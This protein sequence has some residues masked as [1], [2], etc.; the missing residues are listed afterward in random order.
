MNKPDPSELETQY[1]IEATDSEKSTQNRDEATERSFLKIRCPQC[2]NSLNV[3]TEKMDAIQCTTCGCNFNLLDE[4]DQ[5]YKS[6]AIRTI[7]H[8]ELLEQLGAGGFGTVWKA[9]DTALDRVVAVKIPRKDKLSREETEQFLREARAAAQL[10]HPNI[11]GVHEVGKD[12]DRVY[13]VSDLIRG[14]TLEDWL[15]AHVFTAQSAAKLCVKVADALAHA[16]A[17]RVVHRDIKPS[18]ILM[19]SDGEPFVTDF[20]LARRDVGELTV[21]V[22]GQMMGT[23]AYMSPEQAAGEGHH[24]DGRSDIYSLGVVLFRLITGELPFRGNPAMM[25]MQILNDEP[26]SPRKLNQAI[27]RDLETIV[28]KCLEKKREKRY[29]TATDLRSDLQSFIAGEPV[30]ARSIG[31]V[32][33]SLRWIARNP[34]IAALSFSIMGLLAT[35][36]LV[37]TTAAFKIES[38]RKRAVTNETRALIAEAASKQEKEKAEEALSREQRAM[39]QTQ[40]VNTDFKTTMGLQASEKNQ[41]A[42]SVLWFANAAKASADKSWR[43]QENIFRA[44]TWSDN[45]AKPIWAEKFDGSYPWKMEFD[46]DGRYLALINPDLALEVFDIQI[47][48][49]VELPTQVNDGVSGFAWHP[50]KSLMAISTMNA[51]LLFWDLE[52]NAIRHEMQ[53]EQQSRVLT[54]SNDGQMLCLAGNTPSLMSAEDYSM[55]NIAIDCTPQAVSAYFNEANDRV[56]L[57]CADSRV[58][59]FDAT[60]NGNGKTLFESALIANNNFLYRGSPFVSGNRLAIQK[61]SGIVVSVDCENGEVLQELDVGQNGKRLRPDFDAKHL[62]LVGAFSMYFLDLD[63]NKIHYQPNVKTDASN[64][65][66]SIDHSNM[67][68]DCVRSADG[69]WMATAAIDSE[70][71]IWD[72]GTETRLALSIPHQNEVLRCFFSPSSRHL[73]SVEVV[74]FKPLDFPWIL[75]GSGS[76]DAAS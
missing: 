68:Q 56:A 44:I 28:L 1:P 23:P 67:I 9:R 59:L 62:P 12:G 65:G 36:A 37:S 75:G 50:A 71:R 38:S 21:T 7:A 17:Q 76:G 15:T 55:R 27:P 32:Q 4:S 53:I 29:D 14:V 30:K 61:E 6:A 70:L 69:R 43:Q 3:H 54:F 52:K 51:K 34:K 25:M 2:H 5:T 13:L 24:A 31:R 42:E 22:Q 58:I 8:F 35:V 39:Q 57:V 60:E 20:G 26:P 18:N 11:V 41:E 40:E 33:K 48:K 63:E 16:H 49:Y 10:R 73:V 45:V 46:G 47:Q 72:V 74:R 64:S 19:T 66:Q